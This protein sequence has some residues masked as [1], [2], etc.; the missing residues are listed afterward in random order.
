M[1]QEC[2]VNKAQILNYLSDNLNSEQS[3]LVAAHLEQCILCRKMVEDM[4]VIPHVRFLDEARVEEIIMRVRETIQTEQRKE[5]VAADSN[6]TL[7]DKIKHH[8]HN[9]F[10]SSVVMPTSVLTA[11]AMLLIM[12]IGGG[13]FFE[14]GRPAITESGLA[15]KP[16]KEVLLVASVLPG[17]L[18]SKHAEA[19]FRPYT[20][21]NKLEGFK[22]LGGDKNGVNVDVAAPMGLVGNV[23]AIMAVNAEDRIVSTA[24][25]LDRDCEMLLSV[26]PVPDTV[27]LRAI[28]ITNEEGDL[29]LEQQI[30]LN[31]SI[32]CQASV[33]FRDEA[34]G[35]T[36]LFAPGIDRMLSMLKIQS[37]SNYP[38]VT[39]GL[40]NSVAGGFVLPD[41][42]A[43]AS[44]QQ[45]MDLFYK[46]GLTLEATSNLN[47]EITLTLSGDIPQE[48]PDRLSL[49]ADDGGNMLGVL[50]K[51]P[52]GNHV[53]VP[54]NRIDD[55]IT[56]AGP[57]FV[58]AREKYESRLVKLKSYLESLPVEDLPQRLELSS[59]ASGMVCLLE[60]K[61]HVL[62]IDLDGN[63]MPDL[64]IPFDYQGL[65]IRIHRQDDWIGEVV[66][67]I[68]L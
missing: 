35:L 68:G 49:F 9:F 47:E 12:W 34:S 57:L 7:L 18:D 27:L 64:V 44:R 43:T 41:T 24:V 17:A 16:G 60:G 52:E 23:F 3:A 30:F 42:G 19:M 5:T 53:I 33:I 45:S 32:G 58:E 26:D 15:Q 6:R 61:Q 36:L 1:N 21:H 20:Q 2:H 11:A 48:I 54:R 39:P 65:L 22:T 56:N 10:H 63:N 28:G 8:L 4:G 40:V 62:A 67:H 14:N 59:S 37:P 25:L 29:F 55:M 38:E 51:T 13:Y 46:T 66:H 50:I 31:D